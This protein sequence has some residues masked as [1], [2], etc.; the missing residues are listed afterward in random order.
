MINI[1]YYILNFFF[2]FESRTY[3]FTYICLNSI[4]FVYANYDGDFISSTIN[5]IKDFDQKTVLKY[6]F[7][8]IEK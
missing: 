6:A 2:F 1:L 8:S 4:T 3:L 7:E 5:M